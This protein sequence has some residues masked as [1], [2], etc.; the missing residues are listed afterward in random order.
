MHIGFFGLLALLFIGLKLAGFVAWSWLWVLAPLWAPTAFVI[1][2]IALIAVV[3]G[4]G[5]Y[6]TERLRL[7]ARRKNIYGF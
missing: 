6:T 7:K 1:S 4:V 3:A 2:S 5:A